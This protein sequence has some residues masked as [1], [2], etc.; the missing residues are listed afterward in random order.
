M[1][2]EHIL[3]Y[4]NGSTGMFC[5][6]NVPTKEVELRKPLN[7]TC[8]NIVVQ[9]GNTERL[10]REAYKNLLRTFPPAT[11]YHVF[12][13]PFI[14][15]NYARISVPAARYW[16]AQLCSLEDESHDTNVEVITSTLWQNS[17]LG[18]VKGTDA[19]KKASKELG[20][21]LFPQF[22]KQI[23]TQ[24]DADCLLILVWKLQKLNIK[25]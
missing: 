12:E 4:D 9:S 1:I 25:L 5:I 11:T 18:K 13:K 6:F 23:E 15:S 24:G 3:A 21:E 14:H 10:N 20:I 16:E 17:L 2:T 19:K 7:F 22:Q 8:R